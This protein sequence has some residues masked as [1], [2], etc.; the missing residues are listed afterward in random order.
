MNLIIFLI[1]IIITLFFQDSELLLIKI[2]NRSKGFHSQIKPN[3]RLSRLHMLSLSELRV[4]IQ[5][6][7]SAYLDIL[8]N[9]CDDVG[10]NSNKIIRW[11][12]SKFEGGNALV[13]VV[14]DPSI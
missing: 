1:S 12:I 2:N 7:T 9:Y 6:N 4:P 11:Y 5:S 3:S 14:W 8:S 13:E 10:F